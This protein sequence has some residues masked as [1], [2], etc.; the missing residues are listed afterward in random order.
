[1][2][3]PFGSYGRSWGV[4]P[5]R[6]ASKPGAPMLLECYK[7]PHVLVNS[8]SLRNQSVPVSFAC[9]YEPLKEDVA[10]SWRRRGFRYAVLPKFCLSRISQVS[11]VLGQQSLWTEWPPSGPPLKIFLSPDT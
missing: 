6:E 5:G 1:M 4:L 3:T 11:S 9:H 2:S 10:F 8:L 7:L